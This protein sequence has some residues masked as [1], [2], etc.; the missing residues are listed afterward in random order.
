MERV[1]SGDEGR[2][3]AAKPKPRSLPLLS[4]ARRRANQ[5]TPPP[6]NAPFSLHKTSTH[7]MHNTTQTPS[8]VYIN[9]YVSIDRFRQDAETC[10]MLDPQR[11][12]SESD[13]PCTL[14]TIHHSDWCVMECQYL[15]CQHHSCQPFDFYQLLQSSVLNGSGWVG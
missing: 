7:N 13:A 12:E 2:S 4:H 10:W 11:V 15:S 5:S 6:L 1:R 3:L 8:F 9:M 14:L